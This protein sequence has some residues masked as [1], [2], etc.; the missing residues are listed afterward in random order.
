METRRHSLADADYPAP[1]RALQRP[2][3]TLHVRGELPRAAGVAIVGT[4]HPSEEG[5]AYAFDLAAAVAAAGFAVWS[6]GA[7]GIDQAAHEGAL[8]VGGITVVVAGA[9]L[10]Q[11]YPPGVEDL[12]A[13]VVVAGALASIVPDATP[14]MPHIF[15]ARNGVLAAMTVATVIVECPIKSGARSTSAAAR[16]LRRPVWMVAHPPWSPA[17]VA[18]REE[19]RLGARALFHADE[20]LADLAHPSLPLGAPASADVYTSVPSPSLERVL[21]A[22]DAGATRVDDLCEALSMVPS[23]VQVALAMLTLGGHVDEPDGGTFVRRT[24][25]NR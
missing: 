16:R 10:E 12:F 2:P 21:A 22:I 19:L 4:R 14:P 5:A 6:G 23:E 15:L 24:T 8:S 11:P 17:S 13:R 18:V 9:G 7:L 3:E 20:L 1:L 25:G